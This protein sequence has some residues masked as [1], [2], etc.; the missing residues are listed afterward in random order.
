M[1][2]REDLAV[3]VFHN[4]ML[5]WCVNVVDKVRSEKDQHREWHEN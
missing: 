3:D 5:G 2:G 1:L 4:W